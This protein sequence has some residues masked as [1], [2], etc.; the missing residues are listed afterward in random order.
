MR[1]PLVAVASL[2][3]LA[4][5]GLSA[6]APANATK[7]TEGDG[8]ATSQTAEPSTTDDSTTTTEETTTEETTTEE[9]TTEEE[10][11]EEEPA[12]PAVANFHQK[13]TYEDGV[14]VEITKMKHNKISRS[15]AE[16]AEP[17]ASKG[18]P[19]VT[20]TVRV[21][22]GSKTTIDTYQSM[23]VTY[24][25]DGDEAVSPYLASANETD[26]SGK[27][28]PGKSKTGSDS[29]VIPTKFQGDPVLE[30]NV[31]AE[32]EAAVFTGSVK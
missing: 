12:E 25:P 29:F 15:D 8:P 13:Y 24:G 26:I 9:T 16:Y 31:D 28:L 14:E 7:V 30:V 11:T 6:C 18:D 5:F 10:S 21:K 2:A 1:K 27:L 17:E 3:A 20:F 22:N 4:V 32:H 23:T 19:Y